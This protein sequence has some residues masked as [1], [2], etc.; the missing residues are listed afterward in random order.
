MMGRLLM[1]LVILGLGVPIARADDKPAAKKD[2]E[3]VALESLTNEFVTAQNKFLQQVRTSAEAAKKNGS[4][5]KPV[6]FEDGPG[7]QFSPRFLALAEKN[8]DN[9]VGFQALLGALNSSGGPMQK[10]GTWSKGM[11]LLK[12][13]Y[14]TKP[15]IKPLLRPLSASNDEDAEGLIREVIAKNPDRKV[16]ALACKSL[17]TGIESIAEMVDQLGQNATLRRNFESVRGKEY[18][19]KLIASAD[20][21][22]KEAADLRK[23]LNEKY[24]DLVT[25]IS[26]GKP[27]PEIVIQ[28]IDGKS[29]TLSA[30]KGKVVV[31]DIWA[32]WC[33][34]CRAMIPHEREMVERLKNKPFALVSISA[35]EKKETLKDFLSKEKMPWTHWWNGSQGGV[36]ENWEIQAFP[37]IYVIDAK[38]VIRHKNL[39][40]QKLEEAV[41]ELLTEVDKAG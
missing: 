9:P 34:P 23:T 14:A 18:V 32:T 30:L 29:A 37:T 1:S 8:L 35:D 2:S 7:L 21:R 5:P 26:I 38:G 31:L 13:H 10:A 39:R 40:D 4:P 17:A 41:N 6:S 11:T 16:Q 22:K 15:E 25:E 36:I 24:S 20:Q 3:A 33:G 19:A 12:D 28:D 27:A